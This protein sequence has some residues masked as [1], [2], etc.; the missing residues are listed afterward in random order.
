MDLFREL[1]KCGT[2]V[3]VLQRH[4]DNKKEVIVFAP[5]FFVSIDEVRIRNDTDLSDDER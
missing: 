4:L 2:W 5:F 3:T 1:T